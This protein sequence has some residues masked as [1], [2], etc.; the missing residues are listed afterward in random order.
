MH[1]AR[2]HA[3]TFLNKLAGLLEFHNQQ[4]TEAWGN[5]Q[6]RR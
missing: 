5:N 6:V 2:S 1:D 3:S 4:D